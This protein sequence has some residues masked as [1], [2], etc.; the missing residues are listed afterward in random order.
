MQS[1]PQ[2]QRGAREEKRGFFF[3]FL[4]FCALSFVACFP[5]SS[6]PVKA[7]RRHVTCVFL[8]KLWPPV[9][10]KKG[11]SWAKGRL[12]YE[13]SDSLRSLANPFGVGKSLGVIYDPE[14]GKKILV[15]FENANGKPEKMGNKNLGECWFADT[16]L[17]D[18]NIRYAF[19]KPLQEGALVEYT[20]EGP[21]RQYDCETQYDMETGVCCRFVPCNDYITSLVTLILFPCNDCNQPF[22]RVHPSHVTIA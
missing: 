15:K 2:P 5:V 6:R 9:K 20:L 19:L 10:H 1:S 16:V 22:K 12:C 14:Y 18:D 17:T 21:P 11:Q 4:L 7:I 13:V 8:S 3:P